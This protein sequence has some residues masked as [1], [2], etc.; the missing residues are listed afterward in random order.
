[1]ELTKAELQN[2]NIGRRRIDF[3]GVS[4]DPDATGCRRLL[5]EQQFAFLAILRTKSNPEHWPTSWRHFLSSV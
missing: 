4:S 3:A 5:Q 1:M 2:G